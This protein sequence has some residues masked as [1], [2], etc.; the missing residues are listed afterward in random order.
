MVVTILVIAGFQVYWL[1][2]NYDRE[3]RA[4]QI[5]ANMA[6]HDAVRQLQAVKLK[7]KDPFINSGVNGDFKVVLRHDNPDTGL[8]ISK[9]LKPKLVEM[10]NVMR[11]KLKDSVTLSHRDAVIVSVNKDSNHLYVSPHQ[12]LVTRDIIEDV[13]GKNKFIK[14]LYQVDSL[15]DS[16]EVKEIAAAYG[17][18][19]RADNLSVPF[20]VSRLNVAKDEDDSALF[21]ITVGL[22]HPVT[23]HLQLG[24]TFPFLMKKITGPILF[25]IF[26]V[27]VTIVSFIVL[28]RN[29]LKQQRLTE[30]KNEFIGN[31]THE[32]KTP[33]A[34][35][36]VAIEALRN[37][38]AI[39]DPQRTKEYLDIS[40]NE[41]QRLGLLVDKVLKLSMFEKKEIELQKEVFD[42]RELLNEVLG[43]MKLQF[44]KYRATVSVE[45]HGDDFKIGAD[46]LHMT[47][48][49]YNL[50]DN[51]LKYSSV[52][53]RIK[54]TLSASQPEFV[55]L[56][57]TDSGLG[58]PKEYLSRVFDKFFRVPTG[59]RHN[60]KG[61]GLGLSYVREIVR[62][63]GGII[64]VESE[65]EKGT[66]F[67]I[68]LPRRD[69]DAG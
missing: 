68:E 25:S 41:L 4:L 8:R 26:L 21:N 23:Y 3:N 60:V 28:Y 43:I 33:I 50:L 31:I 53:P 57:V 62:R 67:T 65:L 49:L 34:T 48:V 20:L 22:A 66:T 16:L 55:T 61:Y 2:N 1:K 39:D 51:A 38:N 58:I 36:G 5:R 64:S 19:S 27:G 15:Q 29:L 18:R 17:A 24:N 44:E 47:S 63:H 32:L 35:V 6:F 9:D 7:L 56:C 52:E 54:I 42:L 40:A 13:D 69:P 37:F 14:I 45:A 30:L 11:D 59:E 10:I 12:H 46:R